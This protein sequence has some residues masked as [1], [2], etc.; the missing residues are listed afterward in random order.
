MQ[1]TK[2]TSIIIFEKRII[3]FQDFFA[4]SGAVG[5]G[6]DLEVHALLRLGVLNAS[7]L[8][9]VFLAVLDVDTMLWNAL[10]L[11]ALE[12]EDAAVGIIGS[13]SADAGKVWGKGSR[14]SALLG[15]SVAILLSLI[16]IS[17]PTRPY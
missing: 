4:R 3:L 11:A 17:E 5:V 13:D 16:H 12:V 15:D 10:E 2:R 6:C 14:N 8:L 9:D 7:E 1:D